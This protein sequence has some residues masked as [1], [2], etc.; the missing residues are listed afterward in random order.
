MLSVSPAPE[1]Q[2]SPA[3]MVLAMA[4]DMRATAATYATRRGPRARLNAAFLLALAALVEALARLFRAL[5]AGDLPTPSPRP[6]AAPRPDA[7]FPTDRAQYWRS[8]RR[9]TPT[10]RHPDSVHAAAEDVAARPES[11]Q[12]ARTTPRPY[13]AAPQ[14]NSRAGLRAEPIPLFK[15][16][17]RAGCHPTPI[18]LRYNFV[19]L[20]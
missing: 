13:S 16:P 8:Y 2:L 20:I 3:D 19:P 15:N 7:P 18:S 6:E 5:E 10:D 9:T 1:S 11:I 17:K 14:P 12:P 4:G